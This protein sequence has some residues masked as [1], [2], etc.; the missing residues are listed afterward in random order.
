MQVTNNG[1]GAMSKTK[2]NKTDWFKIA[3]IMF[4]CKDYQGAITNYTKAIEQNR[5][6]Q[7]PTMAGDSRSM[8]LTTIKELWLISPR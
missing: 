5:D 8:P 3:A 6:M 4:A 2:K 7:K 1:E